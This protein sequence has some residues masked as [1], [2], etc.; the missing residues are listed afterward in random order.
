MRLKRVKIFGFKTFADKTEFDV[1]GDLIAVVGPNGCGKSNL[2]DAI[3]WALGEGNARQ[4]RAQTNQDVIF[5]GSSRRKPVGYAEVTLLFDNEDGSLPID[6]PEVA[7][8]RRL[9]RS[10]ESDYMINRRN[11]RLRDVLE[12]LA[13][14]GLGRAGYAI[15]GQKDIDQALAASPEE[16]RA[17]VDE[18]AGVQ[19]YRARKQESLKRMAQAQDHLSRV[20][21][22][23]TEIE[24]QREPLREEAEVAVRYKSVL[25]GLREVESGLLI[26]EIAN[27]VKE[28]E[29]QEKHIEESQLLVS[30]ESARAEELEA[31]VRRTGERISALESDMDSLRAQQQSS[32]TA[33]ERADAAMRLSEQRLTSLDELEKNLDHEGTAG[34]QR[35]KE[36]EQELESLKAEEELERE[37]LER[38]RAEFAGAGEDAKALSAQLK[39]LESELQQA[40]EAHT[41]RLKQKAETEHR[42]QREKEIKREIQGIE[43]TVPDLAKAL[44]EAQDNYDSAKMAISKIEAAIQQAAARMQELRTEEEKQAQS[45]RK[46]LA[47]KAALEGR[48]RGI[49]STIEAHEG[50]H[51]GARAVMMA[52]ENNKL[53]G[54]YIPVG[55]CVEVDK[56]YALAIETALGASS[57]DL[58]VRD[59]QDAKRA[60]EYLKAGRLGRATFQPIPLMRPFEPS[61][62]LRSVLNERGVV[63]R[64]SELISCA[65]IYRPVIDS[66]MGRVVIVEDIDV[67]LRLAKTSGWNR[68]V[69]LDGEVVHSSGAV[70]GGQAAKSGYGM[71]Q[72]KA[73]L[74]ELGRALES[75]ERE[76]SQFEK[77]SAKRTKE[78][79]TDEAKI[80]ELRG[81]TREKAPELEEAQNWLQSLQHEFN[82]TGRAK[83]KLEAEL[84]QL[85]AAASVELPEI[86]LPGVEADRDHLIKQL[87]AR[88]ADAEQA[89]N[90]LNE[91]MQRLEQA[92]ARYVAAQK[93]FSN[94]KEAEEHRHKRASNLEPERQRAR[95]DIERHK[96]DKARAT[97]VQAD[98]TAKLQ[99][100]QE[101][102]RE[103]LDGSFQSTE[104]AKEARRNAQACGDTAHQ[105]ELN[106]ARADA[107]R[108]SSQQRLME[109]YGLTEEDALAQADSIEVPSDAA[110][111]VSKLRRELKSMGDVNLGAIEAFERLTERYDELA[112]QMEDIVEGIKQVEASI[113]E[114]D[115]LT[116]DRF[117]NTFTAVQEAFSAIFAKV[118]PGGQGNLE[119]TDKENLLESG[120]EIDVQLPGKNKQRLVLL[121]GGE[122][123]LCAAAFL[124]A[125]LRVKPSP[126]VVLDEV[127][128]PLDGRNVERFIDLL[129]EFKETT[130]FIVITHNPTTIAAA[131]VWLGVTMQEPGVSTLVPTN[132][133][134]LPEEPRQTATNGGYAVVQA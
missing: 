112:T 39:K 108:A 116:R 72:R 99:V 9:T 52:A 90:R 14:S 55:E 109:E 115:E 29:L 88:S 37:N 67:A 80:A 43:S 28:V 100:A 58:I 97:E 68:L 45:V 125:L 98:V 49:E 42:K 10:G 38:L 75:I 81:Q 95:D 48:R 26:V 44:K 126:L 85:L 25:G 129:R 18:A 19:R 13:D 24:S 57:N 74:A 82:D 114:L 101:K 12:L 66:L 86:D 34:Q 70:S 128:A 120:I 50:L 51:Q 76:I 63:G 77:A 11:C 27:A 56:E 6:T 35:L 79:L 8:S 15:V 93:R 30:K 96:K 36:L 60:I 47:E 117:F 105:A 21:D 5:S 16:R 121:S 110:A 2:V 103:L 130:Q 40:R 106:R 71:V 131:P 91:A 118:F 69:T 1:D 124:F 84:A 104:Q 54:E 3:L 41:L 132:V 94:A 87:A 46:H 23:I 127:D 62:G 22:I 4:L 64:A 134:L 53:D 32:I 119:L 102:K 65:S 61:P 78:I 89:E 111:L 107:K 83:S 17:W 133:G 7:V 59:E 123:S 73:D 20:G 92:Q 122:R 33:L 113:K 31:Q